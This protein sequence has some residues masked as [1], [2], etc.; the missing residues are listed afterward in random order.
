M[1]STL[2]RIARRLRSPVA[3]CFVV[4][5]IALGARVSGFAQEYDLAIANGR[6][7][8]PESGLDAV[9]NLGINGS[10][11]EAVSEHP[12]RGRETID[13]RGLVV[14]PGFIDL[15]QHAWDEESCAFKAMDGVTSILELEA[16]TDD[17]D[18][19][20]A[21]RE[22]KL[23][24]NYGASIGHIKARMKVM[25]DFPAFL[26]P[27]TSNAAT[28]APTN[29]ETEALK[30]QIRHGLQR[31]APAVGFGI[32]YTPAATRWEILEMFRVAAEFDASCHVHMRHK[33]DTDP[34]SVE[35]LMEVIAASAITGAPLHIVHINSTGARQTPKLLQIIAEARDQGVD[36]TVEC[37]P[38]TAGMTE[39]QSA[40]FDEGFRERLGVDYGD[41]QWG[42]TGE[43]LT[44]ETFTKYRE[45]GGLVIVHSNPE[46][47]VRGAVEHP[48]T[49]IASDGLEG[50]PRNA[51]TYARILGKYVRE[52]GAL[53]LMDALR[54]MSLM[55]AQRLEGRVPMMK[56]KGR[57]RAGADADLAI[58]DP[59]RVIDKSTF[60][61]AG[62]A[63]E[64][65][66]HVLVNG[67]FVVRDAKFQ[68]DVHPGRPI[69][70]PISP[71]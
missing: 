62:R 16:G 7:M 47:V 6:V 41:L 42:A 21:E 9:R 46:S 5:L 40:I 2:R 15:H 1:K 66:Q 4:A 30:D 31:G 20:F 17:I 49:M 3:L 23:P 59:A 70:A 52:D 43:R 37:Y 8:D 54:K 69:R 60:T 28:K 33:G 10:K 39:I 48:L 19:W 53:E 25:K 11:I 45:A 27:A 29:E 50:H 35:A 36:V 68:E 61:E 58:F 57:I 22:G 26:P 65:F 63:S 34:G 24:V 32:Q 38:Y 64:G 14:A 44:E 56:N 12:L 67:V 13:A 18:R 55:P 51:G 71:E